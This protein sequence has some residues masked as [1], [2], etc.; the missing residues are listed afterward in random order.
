MQPND[1]FWRFAAEI[2]PVDLKSC[3]F[4]EGK[5][6]NIIYQGIRLIVLLELEI[7]NNEVAVGILT[8]SISKGENEMV[9]GNEHETLLVRDL[10]F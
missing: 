2:Q 4:S 1:A 3:C 8:I 5:W 10:S 7:M 9:D 6:E